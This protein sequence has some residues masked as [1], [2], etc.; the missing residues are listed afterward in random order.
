MFRPKIIIIIR[1]TYNNKKGGKFYHLIP[2]FR[3]QVLQTK[4]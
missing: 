3:S 4:I 2:G 1:P